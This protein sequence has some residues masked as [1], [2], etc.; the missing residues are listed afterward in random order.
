MR[1]RPAARRFTLLCLASIAS[2]APQ[3]SGAPGTPKPTPPPQAAPADATSGYYRMPSTDGRT[4]VFVSEGDLWRVPISGGTAQR[5]TSHP[6][7]EVL[8][9]LSPDGRTIAFSASYDGPQEIYV[10]PVDGG[11]PVRRTFEGSAQARGWTPDGRILFHTRA[12][13]TLPNSQ[14]ATVHPLSGAPTR[15]P[16]EEA[17]AGS[18]DASGRTLAFTRLPWQGSATRRYRGGFIE[19]VWSYTLGAPEAVRLTADD[20]GINRSPLW[21]DGRIYITSD[22]SGT[23]NL[24]SMR[25]DGSDAR[26]HTHHSSFEVLGASAGGGTI[27]YQLGADLRAF[28][29]RS[30]RDSAIPVSLASDFDQTREKWITDPF[31]RLSSASLSADGSQI[32]LTVRGR[33]F[34][35]PATPGGRLVEIT[36]EAGVRFRGATFLPGTA[37]ILLLTDASGE[38]EFATYPANGIGSPRQ[39]TSGATTL[40]YPATPSPDG[41]WAAFATR[42]QRLFVLQ[43]SDGSLREIPTNRADGTALDYTDLAW[44]PDSRWLA[45]V[46]IEPNTVSRVWL[47][48][49]ASGTRTPVTS[50]RLD[51][52]APAWSP[53]GT[54]LYFLSDRDFVSLTQSPWG[55][56]QPEPALDAS[57]QV[58]LLDLAGGQRSPWSPADELEAA[59]A[60]EKEKEKEKDTAARSPDAEASPAPGATTA[61]SGK[62]TASDADPGKAATPAVEIALEGLASR[63]HRVPVPAGRYTSLAATRKHL[64]L[65]ER[66]TGRDPSAR[67]VRIE[68]KDRKATAE[69][70]AQGIIGFDVSADGSKVLV[71]QRRALHVLPADGPAPAKLDEPVDLSTLRFTISPRDEWRQILRDA[72]RGQRDYFYVADLHG[73]DWNEVLQRH[74]PLVER[75]RAR[76]ELNDLLRQMLGELE[77]LHTAVYGGD[78]RDAGPGAEVAS[79]GARLEPATDG[80]GWTVATVYRADPDF[81]DELSPLS[82]PG[83]DITAGDVITAIDGV[84]TSATPH[85]NL[86]LRHKAGVPVRLAVQPATGNPREVIV[87]PLSQGAAATLRY[88]DWKYSRRLRVEELGGGRIGYVHLS[89]MDR[90]DFT[91]FVRDFYP[92]F[93]RQGLVIDVRHN[94]GGNIDSW[95][96]GRLLRRAWSYFHS[97]TGLPSWNMQYAFRGHLVVLVDSQTA[98]D[99]ET[100]AEGFRRLG[101]GKVIGTRTWGGGIWIRGLP[102]LV[103]GGSAVA[104]EFGSYSPE[105][106][107]LIEGHGVDPDIVVDNLPHAT[108]QGGDAQLD[109]AVRHLLDRIAADPRPV[110]PM[111]PPRPRAGP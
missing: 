39:I 38:T 37:E 78:I 27:V 60:K 107:W 1:L 93:D 90:E 105:G 51:S 96:L 72:W 98:S 17:A 49:L 58:F 74:L 87:T 92:V 40:R 30:G 24:W 106:T 79:L 25:P 12:F 104:P 69:T 34:V 7:S 35:A 48:E 43:V 75:V 57:T 33:V 100:F 73:A 20:A 80:S 14:L 6:G 41:K 9:Q 86:L 16:L 63:L 32:A 15:L 54:W 88:R 89:A 102:D 46:D 99:G 22:R 26:Q 77:A 67:L 28:D 29:T 55:P 2:L 56:R 47:Y 44:S 13:S 10:M 71:A 68:I 36:R 76:E 53:D 81:P 11:L 52:G 84:P 85:P 91:D 42:D 31:D 97:R 61:S 45:F 5:L 82:R 23:L 3:A 65:S 101:L 59:A 83:V 62:A 94:N 19:Q 110:P 21:I 64:F 103:D 109:A 50:D 4:V 95:I 70:I 108:F 8:P 111:P 66:T 18:F